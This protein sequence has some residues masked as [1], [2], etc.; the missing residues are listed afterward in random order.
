MKKSLNEELKRHMQIV[1]Y[2]NGLDNVIEEKF[3]V[4]FQ[5]Q[6]PE[7]EPEEVEGEAEDAPATPPTPPTPGATPPTP[8]ATGTPKSATGGKNLP[9]KPDLSGGNRP[10]PPAPPAAGAPA[11][12][13]EAGATT[14]PP[15]PPPAP[16]QDVEVDEDVEEIDVTDLVNNTEEVGDTVDK[17]AKQLTDIESRF[18]E[19]SGQLSKMDMVFQKIDNIEMEIEKMIPPTPVE[20]MELRSLDSF[21]Y[22]QRLDDYFDQKK[23]EYKRLRGVDLDVKPQQEKEYTLTVGDTEEWDDNSIGKSFNPDYDENN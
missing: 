20:K 13:P 16:G 7:T 22:N 12:A 14:P 8:A 21:P 18:S 10:V 1:N 5:E 17:F 19:L 9:A 11:G 23:G 4:T 2:A 3:K 15:P 6:E